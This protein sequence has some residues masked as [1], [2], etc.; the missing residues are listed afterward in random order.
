MTGIPDSDPIIDIL[1]GE[2]KIL[3]ANYTKAQI[4]AEKIQAHKINELMD[5]EIF[6]SRFL[7]IYKTPLIMVPLSVHTLVF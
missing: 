2:K 5:R 1:Y 7:W 3:N 6:D 4:E